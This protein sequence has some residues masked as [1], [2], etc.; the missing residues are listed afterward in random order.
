LFWS[1]A[2]AQNPAIKRLVTELRVMRH[3]PQPDFVAG[4]AGDDLFLWHFSI[5]GPPDTPFAG[6][7]YHGKIVF[8][9]Q[10][11][12]KPPDI[13]FLTPNGRFETNRAICLTTT[14]F[15]PESWQP[16]WDVRSMLIALIAFLPTKAEGIGSIETSADDRMELARRSRSWHCP[17]CGLHLPSDHSQEEEEEE[18]PAEPPRAADLAPQIERQVTREDDTTPE[19]VEHDETEKVDEAEPT[20]EKVEVGDSGTEKVRPLKPPRRK[21]YMPIDLAIILVLVFMLLLLIDIEY[22]FIQRLMTLERKTL[23]FPEG[24]IKL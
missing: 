21:F 2:M 6:G 22:P 10:Y 12:M 11:P 9:P 7:I 19:K 16:S 3:D 8:P 15:H 4:P 14:S 23:Y 13:F 5:R 1:V 20:A 24:R 18:G 17:I